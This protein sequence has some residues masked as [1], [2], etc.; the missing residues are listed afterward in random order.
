MSL[1]LLLL[2][3]L[4]FHYYL[5]L[6]FHLID[7]ILSH[8]L[9][10]RKR[11]KLNKYDQQSNLDIIF[12]S[13]D[14]Q[15]LASFLELINT[16]LAIAVLVKLLEQGHHFGLVVPRPFCLHIVIKCMHQNH[17]ISNN[18]GE[19]FTLK[20]AGRLQLCLWNVELMRVGTRSNILPWIKN[21]L[22]IYLRERRSNI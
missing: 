21:L 1:L 8:L 7:V 12:A 9:D 20:I 15:L 5:L 11:F 10:T 17:I 19:E 16:D 4:F 22:K 14:T 3:L 6:I 13:R 18:L 2:L